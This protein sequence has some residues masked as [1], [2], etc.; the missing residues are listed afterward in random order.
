MSFTYSDALSTNRDKVRLHI[1]DTVENS[2]P[3]PDKRN[4]SDNEVAFYLLEEDDRVNG[5]VAYAFEVL[6]SEW[7]SYALEEKEGEIDFDA[8]E[9]SD[10]YLA[11]AKI[12]RAKPEGA[13]ET[14]QAGSVVTLQ[15]TDA[16][17]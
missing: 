12:W 6:A 4:F 17:S 3:R 7:A 5:A 1:G 15:R 2:G 8:K 10:T 14:I 16:Y 11:L 13:A 9:V